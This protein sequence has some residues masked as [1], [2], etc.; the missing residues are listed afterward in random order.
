MQRSRKS[1]STCGISDND[2]AGQLVIRGLEETET[3]TSKYTL[4]GL[5]KDQIWSNTKAY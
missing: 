2:K 1:L 3:K 4:P 5:L